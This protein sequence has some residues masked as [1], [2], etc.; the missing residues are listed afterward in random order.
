MNEKLQAIVPARPGWYVA[1]LNP[2]PPPGSGFGG[3]ERREML[4]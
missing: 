2:A 1:R 3:E 4:S